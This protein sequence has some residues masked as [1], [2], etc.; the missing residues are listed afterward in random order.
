LN[1]LTIAHAL[2]AGLTLVTRDEIFS[3]YEIGTMRA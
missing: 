2:H 3:A 1:A